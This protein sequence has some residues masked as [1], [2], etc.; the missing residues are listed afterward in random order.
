MKSVVSSFSM[1]LV[2]AQRLAEATA[3]VS[4]RSAWINSAI[5]AKINAADSFTM[6]DISTRQIRIAYHARV[7]GCDSVMTCPISIQLERLA[8]DAK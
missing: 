4:N 7:C 2:Q 8:W 3:R 5:D 1:S 6:A